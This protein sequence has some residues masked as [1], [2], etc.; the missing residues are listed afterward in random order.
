M[1]ENKVLQKI[2]ITKRDEMLRKFG[3][4]CNTELY[5]FYTSNNI[6]RIIKFRRLP[7]ARHVQRDVYSVLVGRPEVKRCVGKTQAK[8]IVIQ[9]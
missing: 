8:K 6:V 9:Y 4:S 5:V 1:F 7:R 2:F 3:K